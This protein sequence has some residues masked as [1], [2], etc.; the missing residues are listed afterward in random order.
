MLKMVHSDGSHKGLFDE[1][2]STFR[3]HV[4]LVTAKIILNRLAQGQL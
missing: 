2:H 3:L 1:A 4:A